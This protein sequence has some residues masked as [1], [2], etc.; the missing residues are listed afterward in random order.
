MKQA[1]IPLPNPPRQVIVGRVTGDL[2][3]VGWDRSEASAKTDG[4]RVELLLENDMLTV[5]CD[6]ALILY[7]P[8]AA[9]LHVA[10]I[11]RDLDLRAVT[12]DVRI[13]TIGGDA[14]VRN[15]GNV[16]ITSVARDLNVRNV[17][18][19]FSCLNV[20][21]DASIRQVQG[22]AALGNIGSD[23]YLREVR[24]SVNAVTGS[25]AVLYIH[26]AG[27]QTY[28]IKAGGDILLRVDGA[29]DAAFHLEGSAPDSIRVDLPGLA[30]L[31][32]S[33]AQ[34]FTVGN[35]AATINL[36]AGGDVVVTSRAD[37]WE[38]KIE[39]DTYS[40]DYGLTP[41]EVMGNLGE[42]IAQHVSEAARQTMRHSQRAEAHTE[43]VQRKVE[44][45][46][47]RAEEK[48]R[49]AERRSMHMGFSFG[50]PAGEM[51]RPP[52]PPRPPVPPS[53]PVSDA[54]RLAILRMLQEKKI[55]LQDAEKLL[56]ALEGK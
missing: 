17:A 19:N 32:G 50:R 54:E 28:A 5:V 46:M 9:A 27:G 25:D 23:L 22:Q 21:D 6:G 43:R 37:E 3:V 36:S 45:A 33:A 55:T 1:L 20:G 11:D 49:A 51:P 4:S 39:F 15:A 13:E 2:Q 41:G 10:N 7:M 30:P 26:P 44:A 8:G 40:R 38:S 42:R 56:A 34:S 52:A 16:S 35:G 48:I 14:Q 24:G 31:E 29:V 53:E 47:R 12:G 18:G